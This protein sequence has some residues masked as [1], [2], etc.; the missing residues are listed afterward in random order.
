MSCLPDCGCPRTTQ[1]TDS[2]GEQIAH[3][4][5]SYQPLSEASFISEAIPLLPKDTT[6]ITFEADHNH[7]ALLS[8][9]GKGLNNSATISV[10][11][12]IPTGQQVA[13]R[14][15]NL[16]LCP[17]DIVY[18]QN[19]ILTT[20]QLRHENL[21]PYYCSFVHDNEVWSIMPLMAYGSAGDIMS[22]YFPEGLPELAIAFIMRDALSA[23]DYIHKRGYVHRSVR[24][25]HILISSSGKAVLSGLRYSCNVIQNGKWRRTIHTFPHDSISNLNWLSPE[26]LEQNL[27]GYNS[28]S[29]VYSLGVTACELAN[30]A[31]PYAEVLPTQMLLEKL[32]GY[33]PRPLDSRTVFDIEEGDSEG[34]KLSSVYRK[35][36]FTETFHI[37]TQLCLHRDPAKRPSAAQMLHHPFVK[38][39]KK[40][41]VTLQDLLTVVTSIT[42]LPAIEKD[43][44]SQDLDN[45]TA[46]LEDL[47]LYEPWDF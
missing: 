36:Q 43:T 22:S 13:V 33:H 4:E 23:L 19:E 44:Q 11:R 10:A 34:Q 8:V 6:M 29:D 16:D 27:M 26:L 7:Y 18:L 32:Q 40:M 21:L 24:A 25:S 20:R 47:V 35:R 2:I 30:G 42:D 37:F 5:S 31:V 39:C 17:E 3:D 45:A 15:I 41:N 9:I 28:K 46:H 12:H 14:R 1:E 38:Q